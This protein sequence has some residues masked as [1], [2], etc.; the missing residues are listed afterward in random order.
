M[1]RRLINRG[2]QR[3]E[4]LRVQA[5]ELTQARAARSHEQQIAVLDN[6][7]GEG[8]GATRERARLARL[9]QKR[10]ADKRD[11]QKVEAKRES[12][13][14]SKGERRKAKARRQAEREKASRPSRRERV[15]KQ[16]EVT[17]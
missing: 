14:T 13:P 5:A 3:R 16:E 12:K 11:R 6:K 10:D 4:Q 15:G 9:I 7:L 17:E 1:T 2:K 8:M